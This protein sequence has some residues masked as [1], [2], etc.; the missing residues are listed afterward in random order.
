M[1]SNWIGEDYRVNLGRTAGAGA[2]DWSVFRRFV[3][4]LLVGLASSTL[5]ARAGEKPALILRGGPG[6]EVVEYSLEELAAMPQ[7]AVATETEFTDGMVTFRGPLMRVVLEAL[8]K[9]R[10]ASYRFVAANDYSVDIPAGDFYDFDV[11]LAMEAD[12]RKLSRREKGPLWLMY[13]MSDHPQF[14]GHPYNDR[15]IWQVVTI[16]AL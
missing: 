8:G 12:G 5:I 11:I 2:L 14:R 3:L 16:D 4:A 15:L 13:P 9:D 10:T 6:A 7:V 1:P